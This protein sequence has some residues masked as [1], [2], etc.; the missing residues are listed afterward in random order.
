MHSI[1]L[2]V[3][4]LLGLPCELGGLPKTAP[5]PRLDSGA[6]WKFLF[7]YRRLLEI[8]MSPFVMPIASSAAQMMMNS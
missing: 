4:K 3:K 2:I 7:D 6:G 5:D 1:P 8:R